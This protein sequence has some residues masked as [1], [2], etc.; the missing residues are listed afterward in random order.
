MSECKP[1]WSPRESSFEMIQYAKTGDESYKDEL[2][3]RTFPLKDTIPLMIS[4]TGEVV[5]IPRERDLPV[6]GLF[7]GRGTGKTLML[8][9]ALS[10]SYYHMGVNCAHF[11]DMIRETF[12]WGQ[13]QEGPEIRNIEEFRAPK[14]LPLVHIILMSKDI[15]YPQISVDMWKTCVPFLDILQKPEGYL[16]LDKH[17]S[18]NYVSAM[19]S[20][21]KPFFEKKH[22]RNKIYDFEFV[23][24]I[25]HSAL[26][27]KSPKIAEQVYSAVIPRIERLYNDGILDISPM[28]RLV[29]TKLK[30]KRF[31]PEEMVEMNLLTG[32]IAT[33]GIPVLHTDNIIHEQRFRN[34]YMN[35]KIKELVDDM[36]KY[37]TLKERG[38]A[39][40]ID[41]ITTISYRGQ[42][43]ENPVIQQLVAQGRPKGIGTYYCT[44]NPS[45][46]DPRI[47]SN[48]RYFISCC[49]TT[50]EAKILTSNFS[51][52]S[53]Y[54]ED[55][56]KLNKN[57]RECLAYTSE[58]FLVFNPYENEM[59]YDQGPFIGEYIFPGVGCRPPGEIR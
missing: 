15:I 21:F 25:I 38:L 32:I 29:D 58:R 50:T 1:I 57:Y 6:V 42:G 59:Y 37:P 26:E 35:D 7:G 45:L 19:S 8:A 17:A 44:Q 16:G 31:G 34:A 2:E 52:E 10:S 39:V 51:L 5:C 43:G 36:A 9:S 55:I 18:A 56:A 12:S 22:L 40:F 24:G 47:L 46:V 33:G 49:N 13:R 53:R 30:V 41:E 54:T 27:E 3:P 23:K 4:N 20:A 48:T 28:N 14:M 11:N